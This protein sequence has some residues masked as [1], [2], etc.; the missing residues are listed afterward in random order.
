MFSPRFRK[1]GFLLATPL[2]LAGGPAV[3]GD[4]SEAMNVRIAEM[5]SHVSEEERKM[6]M[7]WSDGKKV[8]EFFC[9]NVALE[10]LGQHF[11]GADRVF[12]ST[13]DDS[14]PELIGENRVK[15]A[16]SVRHPAGWNDFTYE[17]EV[18]GSTGE[19]VEFLYEA[20]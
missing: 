7:E 2:L 8:S 19:V 10:K 13:S 20:K 12:M 1:I 14:P 9:Q 4:L 16:G 11:S 5:L 18:D 6:V 3:G 15:G 17:C